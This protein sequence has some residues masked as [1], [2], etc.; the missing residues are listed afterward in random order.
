[1]LWKHVNYMQRN[2]YNNWFI[3][4][5]DCY[6]KLRKHDPAYNVYL[7]L[8]KSFNIHAISQHTEFTTGKLEVCNF[9]KRQ[10]KLDLDKTIFLIWFKSSSPQYCL[11]APEF[12][13][14]MSQV[15]HQKRSGQQ[16]KGAD[17]PPLRSVQLDRAWC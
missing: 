5:L 8:I 14:G 6:M 7:T 16:V 13:P 11:L 1:M 3:C 4:R 12:L 2:D 9:A 17:S 10:S 15:L